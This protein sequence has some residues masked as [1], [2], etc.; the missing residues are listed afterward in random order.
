MQIYAQ[1]KFKSSLVQYLHKTTVTNYS[2]AIWHNFVLIQD[3]SRPSATIPIISIAYLG[4]RYM[5]RITKC[6]MRASLL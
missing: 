6:K 5:W 3:P 2:K 4:L 1:E